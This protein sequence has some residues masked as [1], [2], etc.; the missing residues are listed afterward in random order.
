MESS[1]MIAE[2]ETEQY[3][4]RTFRSIQ[5][6]YDNDDTLVCWVAFDTYRKEFRSVPTSPLLLLLLLLLMI[7]IIIIITLHITHIN[8]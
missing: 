7:I 3:Q 5:A 6:T 8:S 4:L 2:V 1:S